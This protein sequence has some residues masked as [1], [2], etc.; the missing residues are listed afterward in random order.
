M[1]LKAAGT[2]LVLG[3]SWILVL[4]VL[5][6]QKLYSEVGGWVAG[7]FVAVAMLWIAGGRD[8]CGSRHHSAS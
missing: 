5:K 8:S 2:G 1:V 3:G 4:Q 7:G 6:H